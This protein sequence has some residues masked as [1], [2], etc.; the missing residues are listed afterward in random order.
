LQNSSGSRAP[1]PAPKISVVTPSFNQGDYLERAI[2]SVISQDY[3]NLE[4]IIV[5]G[6]STDDSLSVIQR[7]EAQ[8]AFWV[9]QEDRGHAH[10]LNKGFARSTGDIMA[11]LNADDVYLPNTLRTVAQIFAD[12]ESI[13]WITS[14]AINVSPDDTF[15]Q[16]QPVHKHLC[17]WTQI[18]LRSPPPQHCTFWRRSLWEKA[19]GK[20]DESVR[21]MD[22]ELWLRFYEHARIYLVDTVFAAWR[23][24]PL[25]YSTQN[26]GSL[27]VNMDLAHRAYLEGYLARRPAMRLAMP[28][29]RFYF[30]VIDRGILNRLMF[31]LFLRRSR[32]LTFNLASGRFGFNLS[33]GL[34]PKPWPLTIRGADEDGA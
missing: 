12:H 27:Y 3:P 21:Y 19:G 8:L 1:A 2:E 30:R 18:F 10:A 23:L 9:H 16:I 25:S 24:H 17:R 15:F 22:C 4:Y 6:G 5:D 34:L 31:E 11:W 33:G 28:F 29:M 14:G 7:Y 26:L 20:V 32:M 13:E